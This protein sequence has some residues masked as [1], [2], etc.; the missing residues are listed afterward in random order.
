MHSFIRS[1]QFKQLLPPADSAPP[2]ESQINRGDDEDIIAADD[3]AVCAFQ[4]HGTHIQQ[5]TAASE[6]VDF[7]QILPLLPNLTSLSATY[8]V[9]LLVCVDSDA[10][11]ARVRHGVQVEPLRHDPP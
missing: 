9:S 5:D 6:H 2:L 10:P 8:S 11:G 7:R 1:L 4:T 3:S